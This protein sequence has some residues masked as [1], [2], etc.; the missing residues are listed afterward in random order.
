MSTEDQDM[1]EWTND[2]DKPKDWKENIKGHRGFIGTWNNYTEADYQFLCAFEARH[3]VVGKEVGKSGTP[4]LQFTLYFDHQKTIKALAKK[5]KSKA[6]LEY[7]HNYD[8]CV[9]YCKKDGEYFEAGTPPNRVSVNN[10][11]SIK[12]DIM[13]G[14]EWRDLLIK[15]PEEAMTC[16]NGVRGYYETLKP[17]YHFDLVEKYGT[18]LPWQRQLLD[19]IK[20]PAP[21]R[22][23]IWYYDP[24]GGRGK[25]DM[26]THLV[27]MKGWL[28]LTNGKTADIA[29]AWNGENVV[30]DF[31][32]T[33]QECINYGVMEDLKNGQIFSGKYQS[34]SKIYARPYVV[35][36]ANFE[37]DYSKMS[38]DRWEVHPM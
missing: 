30:F 13:A 4:H 19:R 21:D 16:M 1:T 5:L 28:R 9:R 38:A 7:S 31:S 22:T 2:A 27:C 32:R 6:H 18:Y 3:K 29:L 23:I 10:W 36:F 8:N 14:M 20:E 17:K 12:E 11:A 35:V 24:L 34:V 26:A 33:S 15:Y 37:P 25:T